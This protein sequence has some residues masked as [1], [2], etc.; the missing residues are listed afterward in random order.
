VS[1]SIYRYKFREGQ[2]MQAV[3]ETL[4]LS[5][6]ATEC[7]YG[8]ARVRLDARYSTSEGKRAV[9]VDAT[10]EIGRAVCRVFT[11]F[12][13]KEFGAESFKVERIEQ[14]PQGDGSQQEEAL[15]HD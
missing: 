7:L 3:E 9:V 6:L 4:L 10:T 12:A 13:I 5:I 2:R 15:K 1:K 8:E 11:G 14:H